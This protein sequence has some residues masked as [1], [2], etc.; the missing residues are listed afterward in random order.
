MGG[1]SISSGERAHRVSTAGSEF[2]EGPTAS[3]VELELQSGTSSSSSSSSP[4]SRDR[5]KLQGRGNDSGLLRYNSASERLG[6]VEEAVD[7]ALDRLAVPA[8]S[9]DTGDN[10]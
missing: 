5:M 1:R 7:A 4:Q 9:G 2:L 10:T 3:A 8:A 6:A